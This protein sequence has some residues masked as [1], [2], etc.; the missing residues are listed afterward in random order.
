[1]EL[2]SLSKKV[3]NV[4]D[5]LVNLTGISKEEANNLSNM[6]F[7][8]G[9]NIFSLEYRWF[10]Y[11][12]TWLLKE[13]GYEKTYNFLS[14]DWEKVLGEMNIR[15]KMLF[16]NPLMT[17]TKEKFALDMEIYRNKVDV[18]K[19]EPC[20]RCRSEN[21]IAAEKQTRSADEAATIKISCLSC[22]YK[23]TAQ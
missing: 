9:E 13:V 5:I 7:S 15:K 12:M 18:E 4:A 21:T 8:N 11:E 16:E 10:I 22:G 23:W 14:T 20:R 19:G 3:K 1:M 17:K 6:K 2:P